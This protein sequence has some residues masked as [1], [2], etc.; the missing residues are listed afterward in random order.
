MF[1][2]VAILILVVFAYKFGTARVIYLEFGK[3]HEPE[4]EPKKLESSGKQKFGC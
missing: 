4:S 3:P 2:V 1:E